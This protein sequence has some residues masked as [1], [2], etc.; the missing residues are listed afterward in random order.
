MNEKLKKFAGRTFGQIVPKP[1]RKVTHKEVRLVSL[2]R[3]DKSRLH[4]SMHPRVVEAA[5]WQLGSLVS[6][7]VSEDGEGMTLFPDEVNGRALGRVGKR[8]EGKVNR[9]KL[10]FRLPEELLSSIPMGTCRAVEVDHK[11]MAFLF[12]EETRN[13]SI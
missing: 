10:A 3:D 1:E 7:M 13:E 12:P 11:Y 8:V 4:I 5:R 6:F 2:T 9:K